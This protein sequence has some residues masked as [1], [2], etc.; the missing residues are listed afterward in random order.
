MKLSHTELVPRSAGTIVGP[1]VVLWGGLC[2]MREVALYGSWSYQFGH[3]FP[4]E[5]FTLI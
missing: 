2:L 3:F 5:W 1:M 4:G